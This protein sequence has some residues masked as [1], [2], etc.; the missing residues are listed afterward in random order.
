LEHADSFERIY[1]INPRPQA[2][3]YPSEEAFGRDF[4]EAYSKFE[5]RYAAKEYP[6]ALR[7]LRALV[8]HALEISCQKK[9]IDISNM[10][11]PDINKISG[12]LISNNVIDGRLQSWFHAF[13]SIAN[14]AAHRVFPSNKDLERPN[15]T[16]R[17]TVTFQLGT[18]LI[19][20]LESVL[21]KKKKT[22]L[23]GIS[24]AERFRIKIIKAKPVK[25]GDIFHESS[26]GIDKE[27]LK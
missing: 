2:L 25:K 21:I 18:Q 9:D 10:K 23:R 27:L 1:L 8:Q 19:S 22:M 20:E 5:E 17:I 6:Q 12:L 7:D 4:V 26:I 15:L 3:H 13:S 24:K 14:Q 16:Q 11:E